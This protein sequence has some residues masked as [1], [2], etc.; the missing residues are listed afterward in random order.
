MHETHLLRPPPPR[1][2]LD[3]PGVNPWNEIRLAHARDET[4][5]FYWNKTACG[6]RVIDVDHVMSDRQEVTC[7]NCK[8]TRQ[9]AGREKDPV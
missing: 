2:P 6:L 1:E 4:G 7:R 5:H 9:W 8:R 3:L